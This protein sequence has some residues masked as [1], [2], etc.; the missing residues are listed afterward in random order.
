MKTKSAQRILIQFYNDDAMIRAFP[1]PNK[2]SM[3][4]VQNVTYR[5]LDALGLPRLPK[6]P[7]QKTE[8]GYQIFGALKFRA[9]ANQSEKSENPY[10]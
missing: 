3:F 4:E 10:A 7:W 6:R 1:D 2:L 9:S 8:W 5:E